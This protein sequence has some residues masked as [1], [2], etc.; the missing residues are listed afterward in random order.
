MK[1]QAKPS[2]LVEGAED[3]AA[4]GVRVVYVGSSMCAF[5]VLLIG[6]LELRVHPILGVLLALAGMALL[7]HAAA[8]LFATSMRKE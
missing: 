2:A 1:S 3:L 8:G 7:L 5:G 4:T 6:L